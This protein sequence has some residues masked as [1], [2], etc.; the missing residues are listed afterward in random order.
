MDEA[1]LKD[2]PAL[3]EIIIDPA[4]PSED[5][6]QPV[7]LPSLLRIWVHQIETRNEGWLRDRLIED[8]RTAG[9]EMPL[10]IERGIEA[11]ISLGGVT[12]TSHMGEEFI[13]NY[14]AAQARQA[15]LGSAE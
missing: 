10:Y 11:T 12:V 2:D 6:V 8:L 13:L 15:L 5:Q 9:M 14:W 4:P 1:A 3:T 7:H